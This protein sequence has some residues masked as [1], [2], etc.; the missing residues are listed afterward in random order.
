MGAED[1]R[2]KLILEGDASGVVGATQTAS[3]SLNGLVGATQ[4]AET[5]LFNLSTAAAAAAI[6]LAAIK[7]GQYIQD[8]TMLAARVET[9]GVVMKVVGNNAGYTGA[10]MESYA[11][12]VASMGITTESA[13]QSVVQMASSHMDLSKASALARIAQDAAVIG[14]MNSSEAFDHMI[15]GITAGQI[16]VLRTIGINVQFE[17]SYKK[18]A[19]QLGKNKDSLTENEKIQARTN[20]VVEKGVD[21][22]GAY[23][24]SMDTAAKLINSMKRPAEETALSIGQLFTPSLNLLARQFYDHASGTAKTLKDS[25]PII[26][27]WGNNILRFTITVESEFMRLAMLVDKFGGTLTA[28]AARSYTVAGVVTRAVTIGQFGKGLEDRSAGMKAANDMYAA[29]YATTEAELVKLAEKYNNIGQKP[30]EVAD[31]LRKQSDTPAS[32][33]T[34]N[35]SASAW[36]SAHEKYLSYLEAYNAREVAIAKAGRDSVLYANEQGYASGLVSLGEYLK[37]KQKAV[38]DELDQEYYAALSNLDERQKNL[39]GKSQSDPKQSAAENA[40][41]YHAALKDVE[42]ATTAL[43][44]IESKRTIALLKGSDDATKALYEDQINSSATVSDWVARQAENNRL[45]LDQEREFI[46]A[47]AE[48]RGSSTETELLRIDRERLALEQTWAM[49]TDNFATY[50]AR[51]TQITA[52]AEIQR[53]KVKQQ[54][55]SRQLGYAANGFGSMA[56]IADAFYQ[57][58]G[59]KSKEA[60]LAYQVLKSGETVISTAD[61]AMKAYSALASI[62]YVGP[63]LGAAAAAAAVAAGAVQLQSIWSTSPEGGGSLANVSG[64]GSSG[65]GSS[66]MV[67]QPVTQPTQASQQITLILN[68]PIGERRWFE[69]NL[70]DIVRDMKTRNVDMGVVYA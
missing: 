54:E 5:Q 1:V 39:V 22:T 47:Q 61:A 31:K 57:I 55:T 60:F 62:P 48:L 69:D 68:N 58:S 27:E 43:T 2:T 46:A 33:K 16:E 51:M 37:T 23:S 25:K 49:N 66:N 26:D 10:Q 63:A 3:N 20:V 36:D 8:A 32:S 35:S 42:T 30:T 56:T 29:R 24:A 50:E 67:T 4:Q 28:V 52:N 45:A 53:T 44:N 14:N 7:A 18:L 59:K 19:D 17:A 34:P 38:K 12:S 13:R 64:G 40:K 70:P 15:H 21:I 65:G 9:L 41:E 6:G 11:N